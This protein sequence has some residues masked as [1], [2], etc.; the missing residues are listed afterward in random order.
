MDPRVQGLHPPVEHLRKA[1]DGRDVGDRQAG[2]AQRPRGPPGADQL[3]AARDEPRAQVRESRLVRDGEERPARLR[4]G[5]RRPGRVDRDP[6]PVH[7]E[8]TAEQERNRARQEP[9]LDRVE[10]LQERGLVIAGKHRDCL[11]KDDRAAIERRVDEVHSH[12]GHRSAG[13]ERVADRVGPGEAGQERGVHVEDAAREGREDGRAD[14]AHET[15][16]DNRV[17]ARGAERLGEHPVRLRPAGGLAR[18]EPGNE[19]RVEARF[20]RPVEG[21]ARAVGEHEHDPGRQGVARDPGLE[22]PQ[23]APTPRDTH[24][25]QVVHR[26]TST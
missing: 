21:R 14:E 6:P 2:L 9:V 5:R 18:P 12:A 8:R 23:V 7:P 4:D 10:P 16:Q 17:R 3:E 19:R 26:S 1:G 24:R 20:G 11:G 15:G 25:D 13:R 22:G